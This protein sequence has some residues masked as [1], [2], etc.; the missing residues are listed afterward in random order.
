MASV[1]SYDAAGNLIGWRHSPGTGH[2]QFDPSSLATQEVQTQRMR[3]QG[4]DAI[5]GAEG[6]L[7]GFKL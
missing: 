1:I 7:G 3:F 6:G 4:L 5:A 2:R